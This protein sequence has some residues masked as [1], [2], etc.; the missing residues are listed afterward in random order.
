M[1]RMDH[2]GPEGLGSES[3]RKLGCCRKVHSPDEAP[4]GKLG[5]GMGLRRHVTENATPGK[6]KQLRC[7]QEK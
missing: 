3:G 7:F 2:T 5:T 4:A 6:R 1:P